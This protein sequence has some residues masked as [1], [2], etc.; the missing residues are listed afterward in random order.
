VSLPLLEYV[1]GMTVELKPEQRRMIKEQLASGQFK[2]VDE[3]LTAALGGLPQQEG[4]LDHTA[5]ERMVGF[6]RT[7]SVKLPPAK[8][9]K[10]SSA[11]CAFP[12]NHIWV[13]PLILA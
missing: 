3:V 9:L 12:G 4:R 10:R 1:E 6:S 7:H 2:S 11:K 8:R 13:E 5:V